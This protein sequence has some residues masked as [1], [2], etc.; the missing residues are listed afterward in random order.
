MKVVILAG[1]RGTRLAEETLLRPKPMVEV[2]GKPILWHIMKLYSHYGINDFVICLG[3]KGYMIKEYF[4]NY[5]LHCSDLT[6]DMRRNETFFHDVRSDPWRV[7][8]VDTGDHTMTGG[9]IKRVAPYLQD[10]AEFCLTYGDGVANVDIPASIE[11]HRRHGW[12]VTMTVVRPPARFGSVQL[13]GEHIK[14]FVEKPQAYEGFINGGFFVV[15]RQTLDY[16]AGDEVSWEYG[17]LERI[18]ADGRLGAFRHE[19]FWQAMDNIREKEHL[20]ELW[21]SGAAPWKIWD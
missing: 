16:I 20:E 5:M 9:R 12:G 4:H 19:G 7:T 15:S 2:G 17:P 11:F 6:I 1:G 13:E 3:Y 18:T 14:Q 21:A 10:D 8:L